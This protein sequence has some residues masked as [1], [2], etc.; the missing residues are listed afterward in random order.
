VG[1]DDTAWA[2]RDAVWSAVYAGIDPDPANAGALR[3]WCTDYWEA[4]HPYSMGG[5]YVNFIGEHEGTE[6][7][8][9]TYR[10]HYDRL[11]AVKHAYDPENLFHRNQNVAPAAA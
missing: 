11:A 7:V 10:S 8:R 2:Y 9:A 6:R 4:L 1:A 3:R 5:G